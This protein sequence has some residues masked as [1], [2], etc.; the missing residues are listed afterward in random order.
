MPHFPV[1]ILQLIFLFSWLLQSHEVLDE[2]PIS[3]LVPLVF[4]HVCHEWHDIV[5]SQPVVWSRLT[6][7]NAYLRHRSPAVIRNLVE[8][9]FGHVQS[10]NIGLFLTFV[11]QDKAKLEAE[12]AEQEAEQ[13]DYSFLILLYIE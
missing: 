2:D 7:R 9:W 13:E 1:E 11:L 6:L 8:T 4:L 3:A 12:Q 10:P 5:L